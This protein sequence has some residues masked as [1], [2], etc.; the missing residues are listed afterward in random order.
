[1]SHGQISIP[2]KICINY[3]YY[4]WTRHARNLWAKKIMFIIIGPVNKTN[5]SCEI[6]TTLNVKWWSEVLKLMGMCDPLDSISLEL[7]DF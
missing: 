6:Y 5:V 3:V 7:D 1:M 4:H 2:H